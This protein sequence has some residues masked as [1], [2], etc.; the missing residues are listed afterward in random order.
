MARVL[1]LRLSFAGFSLIHTRS[2]Q[3]SG[4]ELDVGYFP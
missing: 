1:E 3:G 2:S 4:F